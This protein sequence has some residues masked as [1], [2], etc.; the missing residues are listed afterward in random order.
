MTELLLFGGPLGRRN[1]AELRNQLARGKNPENKYFHLHHIVDNNPEGHIDHTYF[2]CCINYLS[3]FPAI[4]QYLLFEGIQDQF[5]MQVD[6][7]VETY[8]W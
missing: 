1:K 3:P 7:I 2:N 4:E 5:A 8:P 6:K